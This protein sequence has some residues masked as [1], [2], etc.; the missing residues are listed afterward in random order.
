MEKLSKVLREARKNKRVTQEDVYLSIG[1]TRACYSQWENDKRVPSYKNIK[2]L[3][4][5]FNIKIDF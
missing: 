1:V 3:E 2:K 5:F 4:D